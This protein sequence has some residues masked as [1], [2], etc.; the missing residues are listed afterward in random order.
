MNLKGSSSHDLTK[1]L[2][3]YLPGGTE[4][5]HDKPTVSIG[6]PANIQTKHHLNTSLE[7]YCYA[8]HCFIIL[9]FKEMCI[10]TQ[11]VNMPLLIPFQSIPSSL[12]S[13][14]QI[15]LKNATPICRGLWKNAMSLTEYK[16]Y[17]ISH[18]FLN[19]HPRI[20]LFL[21]LKPHGSESFACGTIPSAVFVSDREDLG[22]QSNLPPAS[23]RVKLHALDHIMFTYTVKILVAATSILLNVRCCP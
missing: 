4:E 19:Y 13:M 15:S 22:H 23:A 2:S 8:N 9:N 5:C 10:T 17:F 21:A 20:Y 14:S 11:S 12:Q 7:H 3:W 1:V 18:F 16:G 6:I